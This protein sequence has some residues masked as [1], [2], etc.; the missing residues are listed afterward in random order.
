MRVLESMSVPRRAE[1]LLQS[2]GADPELADD[3]LGDLA[4]EFEVRRRWDGARVARRWYYRE[5]VRTAPCLLRD[6][7]RRFGLRDAM[8]LTWALLAGFAAE[9][10]VAALF[11][12][13]TAMVTGVPLGTWLH[14]MQTT[15][16]VIPWLIAMMVLVRTVPPMAAGFV[17]GAIGRRAAVPY[18]MLVSGAMLALMALRA[19]LSGVALTRAIVITGG[20]LAVWCLAGAV[21][22]TLCL[23]RPG[24]RGGPV[25]V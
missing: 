2:L 22:S 23:Q 12:R 24:R 25:K 14:H 8:P 10:I 5:A 20:W 11:L 21:V 3:V 16:D 6:W 15:G 9:S 1:A 17:V 18:S 7:R 13:L 4:E 19:A